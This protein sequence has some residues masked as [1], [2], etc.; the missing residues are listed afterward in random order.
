[1]TMIVDLRYD[2]PQ[3]QGQPELEETD[4][5]YIIYIY[6]Y[7]SNVK[8]QVSQNAQVYIMCPGATKPCW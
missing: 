7:K 2:L 1:M 4:E 6:I 5:I 3:N 8:S